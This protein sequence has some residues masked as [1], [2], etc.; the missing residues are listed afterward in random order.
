MER[1]Q[2]KIRETCLEEDYVLTT[3]WSQNQ[4]SE[5]VPADRKA[6]PKQKAHQYSEAPT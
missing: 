3:P 5:S 4:T 6:L 1:P 2:Q